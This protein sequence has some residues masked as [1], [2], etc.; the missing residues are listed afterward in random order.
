[1]ARDNKALGHVMVDGR[2]V[3]REQRQPDA[4]SPA[5]GVSSSVNDLTRWMRL[6]MNEGMFQGEQVIDADALAET[7]LP[8]MMTGLSP[9]NQLPQFY[10]LG[11]NVSYTADG[12]HRISHSG[13]F[14]MGT[15]TNVNISLDDDLG[16]VVLTNGAP[17]GVA[18]GLA[19]NFMDDA[20][21]GVRQQ[22]WLE[23]YRGIMEQTMGGPQGSEYSTPPSPATSAAANAAYVGRYANDFFGDVE[24]VEKD[25]GLAVLIGPDKREFAMT[26]YD[27]DV[28][29]F[30][31]IGENASG[32]SGMFFTLDSEGKASD[33]RIG[34]FDIHGEG[35]FVRK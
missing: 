20:L 32:A 1:M 2:W 12:R 24:V 26:H 6:Q 19:A 35:T 14:A 8:M 17:V 4:Q 29:T 21:Y 27:R 31:T 22:D 18:E 25:G 30:E 23:L 15:G 5:G 28:F 11:W 33:L 34:A 13:G 10:G 16:V 3:H 9:L 7:H